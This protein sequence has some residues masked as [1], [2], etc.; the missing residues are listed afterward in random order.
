[1]LAGIMKYK[2]GI[3]CLLAS[4]L[5]WAAPRD[6]AFSQTVTS[7]AAYEF[8]EVTMRANAPFAGNPF[9]DISITGSFGPASGAPRTNVDGFCDSADGSVFR[10]RFMPASPGDY[11]YTVKYAEQGFEKNYAGT[12]HA[13]DGGRRGPIRVDPDY[14]WHFIWEGTGS[15][16]FQRHHR[17]LAD[18]LAGRAG[19]P[20]QH[21]APARLKINRMRVLLSWPDQHGLRRAGDEHRQVESVPQPVAGGESRRFRSSRLRLHAISYR[22]LA[23]FRPHAAASRANAT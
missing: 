16:I 13:T 3:V 5:V 1:M 7:V 6:V 12:F 4:P 19:Y 10:I 17:L 11:T 20:Q 22:T 9:T 18:G 2:I 15:T 14:P 23:A 21:R 8:V